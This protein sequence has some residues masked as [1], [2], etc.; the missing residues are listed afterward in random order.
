MTKLTLEQIKEMLKPMVLKDVAA[1]A[2]VE[3]TS[4]TRLMSGKLQ[5]PK[6]E[7]V[8][9]LGKYLEDKFTTVAG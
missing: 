2:D 5:Q 7:M 6:Y 9:R 8:M 3:Y 1:A 4:L